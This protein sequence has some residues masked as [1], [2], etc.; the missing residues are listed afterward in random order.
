M[1]HFS[2]LRL[3]MKL[4]AVPTKM[5]MHREPDRG[6]DDR[7]HQPRAV[8]DRRDVAE[9][10]GGDRDHREIDHIEEADLAVEVVDQPAAV[11]PVDQSRRHD[12]QPAPLP[13]RM[14][15]SPHT[16]ILTA[17]RSGLKRCVMRG[18]AATRSRSRSSAP[19]RR[20][21]LAA[22]S[23]GFRCGEF[24]SAVRAASASPASPANADPLAGLDYLAR[25]HGDARQVSRRAL[26]Q[27]LPWSIT[28]SSPERLGSGPA[29]IT[30]PA[31]RGADHVAGAG[32]EVD[33]VMPAAVGRTALQTEQHRRRRAGGRK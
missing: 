7:L 32:G 31:G 19:R 33:P 17:R 26:C 22:G 30:V 21:S 1:R 3:M 11:P 2:Q 16:G 14:P 6:D 4:Y 29:K 20:S 28:T 25:R 10:G 8:A 12:Q 18:S 27:P 5:K 23:T 13:S 24:R 9:A 15:R